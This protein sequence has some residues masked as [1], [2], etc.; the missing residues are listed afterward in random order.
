MAT[1]VVKLIERE[2]VKLEAHDEFTLII[3][4]YQRGGTRK[5]TLEP[6][7]RIPVELTIHPSIDD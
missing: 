5:Y 1:R 3:R 2:L 4:A 7:P 6:T